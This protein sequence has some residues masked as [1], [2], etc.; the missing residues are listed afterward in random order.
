MRSILSLPFLLPLFGLLPTSTAAAHENLQVGV[1]LDRS[2]WI[3]NVSWT[4]IAMAANDFYTE[5]PNY[6]TRLSLHWRDTSDEGAI[7]AASAALDLLQNAGVEAVIGPQASTQAKFVAELGGRARVPVLSFSASLPRVRSSPYFFHTAWDGFS[8]ARAVA[9]LVNAFGWREAVT[10]LED[11]DYGA[12]FAPFLTDALQEVDVPVSC[13]SMIA[14]RATGKQIASELDKLR[15]NRTRVFIVHM[16]SYSLAFGF[17]NLTK[18]L[19]MMKN[20]Y[21]WIVTYSLTDMVDLMGS[22]ALDLMQGVIGL[23]PSVRENERLHRLNRRWKE[24]RQFKFNVTMFGLW[25]YDTVWALAI[26]AEDARGA[27]N[28]SFMASGSTN[29]TDLGRV[30]A[31]LVGPELRDLLLSSSFAGVGGRFRLDG[32]VLESGSYEIVNVVDGGKRR[33][34]LWSPTKGI[35]LSNVNVTDGDGVE[36]PGGGRRKPKGWEWPIEM[37]VGIPVKPGFEQFVEIN[38][39]S[40]RKGYCI[41]LFEAAMKELSVNF[42]YKRFSNEQG[43][44][45]G[46]YDDMVYQLSH[47]RLD[48]VVGDLT[49]RENRTHYFDFTQ[50]FTE[51]GLAMVVPTRDARR[52]GAWTFL[53]PLSLSLWLASAAFFIFTGATIWLLEHRHNDDFHGVGVGPVLYFSFSTLVFA[54]RERLATNSGR[55]VAVF[56]FFVVLILQANYTARLTS[57][58]TVEQLTP[59]VEDV[60]QLLKDG[61]AV[62]YQKD[63]FVQGLLQSLKFNE[64]KIVPYESAEEYH[65]ALINGSVAAIV[66]EVPYLKVFM[67]RYCH[68]NFKM[69]G[70]IYKSSGFGFAFPKG[71]PFVGEVS[72]AILKVMQNNTLMDKLEKNLY[73][74]VCADNDT[75]TESSR[76]TFR[77]FSGLFLI[78]GTTSLSALILHYSIFFL[79]QQRPSL[80]NYDQSPL[81]RVAMLVQLF[82]QRGSSLQASEDP[83]PGEGS[84]R[85]AVVLALPYAGAEENG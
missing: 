45:N 11:S 50:P 14:P 49:I 80:L 56:W 83:K 52:K 73:P 25:A 44:S 68:K 10:V 41:E 23:T 66:D 18:S 13:R 54:H 12:A 4:C 17:F 26:A 64:S 34:G 70:P 19:G 43:D 69:V 21:V 38:E 53:K 3:G 39:S 51:S 37:V 5:Y 35:S 9:S 29:S 63:S 1:I 71:S 60:A 24:D 48:A 7:P 55:L 58:L 72:R 79:R 36:W 75:D 61:S 81:R 67:A 47:Q 31:S 46:T 82:G 65:Q 6:S 22:S 15:A 62:G 76:L 42:S 77:I 20:G 59:T 27:L 30:G 84:T 2:T 16:Y 85:S 28:S 40:G 33:I 74:T 8:Q 57:M 78:T 32:Q